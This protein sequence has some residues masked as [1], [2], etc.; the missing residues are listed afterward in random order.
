MPERKT[1]PAFATSTEQVECW[2][3]PNIDE[4]AEQLLNWVQDA[5]DDL[6]AERDGN[7]REELSHVLESGGVLHIR[8]RLH[9]EQYPPASTFLPLLKEQIA[10]F[11]DSGEDVS[12][13]EGGRGGGRSGVRLTLRRATAAGGRLRTG[14]RPCDTPGVARQE[15]T[16]NR[17]DDAQLEVGRIKED[18]REGLGSR[19]QAGDPLDLKSESLPQRP[20][21]TLG[22]LLATFEQFAKAHPE[23]A[24]EAAEK[25]MQI[26]DRSYLRR[27]AVSNARDILDELDRLEA[28]KKEIPRSV[29]VSQYQQVLDRAYVTGNF[30]LYETNQE[31]AQKINQFASKNH[32]QL[33]FGG[34]A[35]TIRCIDRK[36]K[37]Y[38]QCRASVRPNLTVKGASGENFPPLKA[39]SLVSSSR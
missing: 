26:A 39:V 38:F 35:V 29:L 19:E 14:D 23:E 22:D 32:I 20:E 37:G 3:A 30:G 28:E 25:C 7:P 1:T 11:L 18:D 16:N 17:A 8:C 2:Y 33:F 27:V 21:P 34:D 13:E 15:Q 24:R 4:S 6:A 12:A 36:E 31:V 10:R 9:G 5:L